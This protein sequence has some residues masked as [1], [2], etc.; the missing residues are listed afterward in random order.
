MK[1]GV[2][3]LMSGASDSSDFIKFIDESCR[4]PEQRKIL[5]VRILDIDRLRCYFDAIFVF[6]YTKINVDRLN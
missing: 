3:N 1:C 5:E 6:L 2:R 4:D